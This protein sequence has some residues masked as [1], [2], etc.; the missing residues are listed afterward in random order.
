[1]YRYTFEQGTLPPLATEY[2]KNIYMLVK[3]LT[4]C[5][6]ALAGA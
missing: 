3:W 4:F 1:M 6:Y 5:I 2:A